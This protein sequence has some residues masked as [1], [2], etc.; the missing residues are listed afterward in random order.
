MPAGP[1]LLAQTSTAGPRTACHTIDSTAAW[2]NRQAQP[3]T[4]KSFSQSAAGCGTTGIAASHLRKGLQHS[5]YH[6]AAGACDCW[7]QA[8]SHRLGAQAGV[9]VDHVQAAGCARRLLQ[10][11]DVATALSSLSKRAANSIRRHA[12]H[13]RNS[14]NPTTASSGSGGSMQ[15]GRAPA[16]TMGGCTKP[17]LN[18][19]L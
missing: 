4:S 16:H 5:L 19:T 9:D 11:V 14:Y 17:V 13:L 15:E 12:V 1:Q 10:I 2:H 18:N 7:D 3:M 6:V 8:V